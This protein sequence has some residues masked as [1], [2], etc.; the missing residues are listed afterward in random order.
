[1]FVELC[2]CMGGGR[3]LAFMKPAVH[4]R[5]AGQVKTPVNFPYCCF[6][7]MRHEPD[8]GRQLG[9]WCVHATLA[10]THAIRHTKLVPWA[11]WQM[12]DVNC[13]PK[14]LTTLGLLVAW[15]GPVPASLPAM[16]DRHPR[17]WNLPLPFP[18]PIP[19]NYPCLHLSRQRGIILLTELLMEKGTP[20]AGSHARQLPCLCFPCQEESR[21]DLPVSHPQN[22]AAPATLLP[23]M[24]YPKVNSDTPA[25]HG[26]F[27][28]RHLL[29]FAD[30]RAGRPNRLLSY[31]HPDG[32]SYSSRTFLRMGRGCPLGRGQKTACLG[33][34]GRHVPQR[35]EVT[36]P[37]YS[38]GPPTMWEGG[39]GFGYALPISSQG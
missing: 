23:A 17:P 25:G 21:A 27:V 39:A 6:L 30:G 28:N 33:G 4:D 7:P 5:Q 11:A 18:M 12:E 14:T 34:R 15:H 24:P 9:S 3:Q 32:A 36:L 31:L 2:V 35:Q 26:D 22:L 20:G 19:G 37:W 1:M 38:G 29:P 8:K 13:E 10:G 16:S